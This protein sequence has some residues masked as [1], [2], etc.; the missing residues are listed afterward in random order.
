[1]NTLNL[2]SVQGGMVE[3]YSFACEL[4][5]DSYLVSCLMNRGL[6]ERM[7]ETRSIG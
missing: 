6:G 4:I 5:N 2:Y 7:V 1:M 3:F